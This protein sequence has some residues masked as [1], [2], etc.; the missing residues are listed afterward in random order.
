MDAPNTNFSGTFKQANN[1]AGN[2]VVFTITANGF[3]LA[4]IP[5]TASDGAQRAPLN[6]IQI[7]PR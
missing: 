5:S 1:S 7:V 2:Y 3:T 4:A 6:G